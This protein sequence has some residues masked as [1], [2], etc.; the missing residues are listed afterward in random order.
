MTWATLA[1]AGLSEC[2]RSETDCMPGFGDFLAVAAL[3]VVGA[4]VWVSLTACA[5]LSI[6]ESDQP[7]SRKLAWSLLVLGVPFVGAIAW[8]VRPARMAP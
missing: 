1:E 3:V 4:L 7:T 6:T 8:F 2:A 5:A